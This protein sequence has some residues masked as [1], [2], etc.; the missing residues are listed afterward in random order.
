MITA[1][2]NNRD[3]GVVEE[4]IGYLASPE[5]RSFF[6]FAGAGS[7][8]T[9]TLVETLRRLTGLEPHA[10]GGQLAA[11]L[12]SHGQ[13][14]RVITYTRNAIAVIN[15][16]LGENDLTNVSTI[17]G[18]CWGLI[19]GFDDDIRE[20]LLYI[21]AKK[22][23]EAEQTASA[24]ARGPTGKD[25]RIIK[26]LREKS[27][28]IKN[29]QHFIYHP[30]RNTYG[31]GALQH[32]QVVSVAEWLLANRPTLTRILADRHPIILVDESQDTM[33]G[34]LAVLLNVAKEIPAELTLGF[35]GDHRQRIYADGHQ[36]LPSLIPSSWA[37]PALQMNH[38]SQK[39]IVDLIN[40][41]WK[42]KKEGRTQPA[43]GV[44]Q[45]SRTEKSAGTVR[46][47]VGDTK[48]SA[49]EKFHAEA[50]CAHMMATIS[51]LPDWSDPHSGYQVL[52]L[53]HRLAARRGGFLDL[54][55]ALVLI[56]PDSAAPQGNGE[57]TGPAAVR[58]LL[59]ETIALAGCFHGH[60]EVDDYSVVEVLHEHARLDELSTDF[61]IQRRQLKELNSAI[62][63]FAVLC[64]K[65]D[66]TIK[67]VISP[68]ISARLF[69]IDDRLGAAF[70]DNTP[71]PEKPK[72]GTP[73]SSED[74]KRRGWSALFNARWSEVSLYQAYLEGRS[75][76]STHQVVKGSEFEHVLV[77]MDDQEA[78]GFL[79][80]YDKLF[81]A[82]E[83]SET[84]LDNVKNGKETTIDRTLRLLYVTCSRARESL[85]LVLWS[86][87]PKL[88]LE[89][90]NSVGW[91]TDSEINAIPLDDPYED[92]T[93]KT[94][95]KNIT[96]HRSLSTPDRKHLTR[97]R[98]WEDSDRGLINC[99]EIGRKLGS[100]D[101]QLMKH[102]K[103]GAL[104]VL[105]W[106][107]GV[108]R[109]INKKQK[110]GSLRYLAQWQGIRGEDLS[111][112]LDSE[113]IL[114][115]TA[116]GMIVTFTPDLTKLANQHP[117]LG[118]E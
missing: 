49:D 80:S 11:R 17:H 40:N 118:D 60:C 98:I 102:C 69:E 79:F 47:F 99:W 27:E 73:E 103:S 105:N 85:A 48:F 50:R 23:I 5:P 42:T 58:M 57:N 54:F 12:R 70:L 77:V 44:Q 91:F 19:A 20:A 96:L 94:E 111:I 59:R 26:D 2:D 75:N 8:K 106:K 86:S 51:N 67:E 87:D 37:R 71:P 45:Y 63:E 117:D 100:K 66:A 95:P 81:G 97:E 89:K 24:R 78:E 33:K 113:T 21:N 116:T 74:R 36:D 107:G 61:E 10:A 43:S 39:R 115:C 88:A 13:S 7:G 101:A 83:L 14:I 62:Q 76:L 104:P 28:S 31:D 15:G 112:S 110:F 68:I 32:A 53:E 3:A 65:P 18:F 38:R 56:D 25:E 46:I 22:L 55:N 108:S 84:D 114:T 41:I 52:A 1:E 29:T 34:V 4:I 92:T 16:R 109:A 6:L 64:N 93:E 9:R 35:F 82:Q 72:R 30:D 90:I